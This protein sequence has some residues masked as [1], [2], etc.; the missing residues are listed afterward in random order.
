MV[1]GTPFYGPAAEIDPAP[2][3]LLRKAPL[4][5]LRDPDA[6]AALLPRLGLNDEQLE[7]FPPA[8]HG[9][10]GKGVFHWQYPSQFSRYLI[11]LSGLGVR[12]YLEIGTRHG[13]TFAITVEYL[14]RFGGLDWALGVGILPAPSLTRWA[15]GIDGVATMTADSRSGEFAA[16]VADRSPIDLVLIDGDH[17]YEGVR[18]D[19]ELLK[20][21]ARLIAFH[22]IENDLVPGV[23]RLWSEIRDQMADRYEFR[24]FTA[25]YAEVTRSTGLSLLGLGLAVR[26]SGYSVKPK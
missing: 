4:D 25:Q 22:D 16:M 3:E 13:G 1:E 8:L 6:L 15:E 14:R 12:N 18:A 21:H 11:A 17:E 23:P 7:H 5:D 2:L 20:D 19:F 26:R 9:F 10:A 24:E